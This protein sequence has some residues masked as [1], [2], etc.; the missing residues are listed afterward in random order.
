ME[1]WFWN[2]NVVNNQF[3]CLKC[4]MLPL[5]GLFWPIRQPWGPGLHRRGLISPKFTKRRICGLRTNLF[6][7]WSQYNNTIEQARNRFPRRWFFL[8]EVCMIFSY[9]DLLNTILSSDFFNEKFRK[10]RIHFFVKICGE[11]LLDLWMFSVRYILSRNMQPKIKLLTDSWYR[12][13]MFYNN[14]S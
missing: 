10:F 2:R 9:I 7:G 4:L 5:S 12:W 3:L 8:F 6:N 13:A 1:N 11:Q 14:L